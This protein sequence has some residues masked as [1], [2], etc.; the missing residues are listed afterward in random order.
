MEAPLMFAPEIELSD[1]ARTQ[2]AQTITTPGFHYINLIMRTEVSKFAM[3]LVNSE[4]GD[5]KA[6]LAKHKLSRAAALF[7]ARVISRI[8]S[9]AQL[10]SSN[11]AG[12]EVPSDPTEGI[13]DIGPS[14]S[15]ENDLLE[16]LELDQQL[17]EEEL[18]E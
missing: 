8:N 3:D 4:E 18:N 5:D 7:Y 15:T 2:I 16:G 11:L 17:V 12:E 14:A 13:I 6:V 10:G 9:E 1:T